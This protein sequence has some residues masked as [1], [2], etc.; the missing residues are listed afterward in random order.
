MT[1]HTANR[2]ARHMPIR[3]GGYSE[4]GRVDDSVK[5]GRDGMPDRRAAQDAWVDL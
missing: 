1:E 5:T 3:F 2:T 4:A